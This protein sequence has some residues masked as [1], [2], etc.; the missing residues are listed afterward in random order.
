MTT[1]PPRP[2]THRTISILR[3]YCLGEDP[4]AFEVVSDQT[5]NFNTRWGWG[6]LVNCAIRIHMSRVPP[7]HPTPTFLDLTPPSP[8]PIIHGRSFGQV[9]YEDPNYSVGLPV[10]CI[11]G[12]HDDPSRDGATDVRACVRMWAWACFD[13]WLMVL[14]GNHDDPSSDGATDVRT[15]VGVGVACFGRWLVV[16]CVVGGVGHGLAW[17]DR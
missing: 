14:C 6:W 3:Q 11:H 1:I 16:L 9:N 7:P 10:F 15:Y 12:N 5:Q 4:V 2:H 8:H 13:R 17:L